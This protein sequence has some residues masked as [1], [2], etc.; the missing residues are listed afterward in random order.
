[1]EKFDGYRKRIEKIM[2]STK[3]NEALDWMIS[4]MYYGDGVSAY[5]EGVEKE[6]EAAA[7]RVTSE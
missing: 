6:H 2:N 5:M 4:D 3:V 1:M 7:K